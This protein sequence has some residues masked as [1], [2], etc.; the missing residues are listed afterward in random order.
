MRVDVRDN[1]VVIDGVE[2]EFPYHIATAG[3]LPNG[4]IA[5]LWDPDAN[6]RSW[7][8]FENLVAIDATGATRWRAALPS[9]TTGD[10]YVQL[11]GTAPLVAQSWSCYRCEIASET[12]QI[13][14][15]QFTK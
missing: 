11:V 15:Q 12:G 7:G 4:L 3:V 10:C 6:P 9:T 8:T 5:V 14:D 1:V 2:V 13:R